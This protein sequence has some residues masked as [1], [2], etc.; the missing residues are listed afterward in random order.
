MLGT[1]YIL[2]L[3]HL[4]KITHELKRYLWQKLKPKK[5]LKLNRITS[6]KKVKISI[7]EVGTTVVVIDNHMVIIPSTN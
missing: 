2:K 4:L 7:L 3:G 6:K 1:N 5:T